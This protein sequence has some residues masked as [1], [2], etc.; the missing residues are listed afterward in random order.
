MN[1][2]LMSLVEADSSDDVTGWSIDCENTKWNPGLWF[3]NYE[4]HICEQGI[5]IN[6]RI[7]PLSK[8]ILLP[9][10]KTILILKKNNKINLIVYA[11][12]HYQSYQSFN[13]KMA[14]CK[15]K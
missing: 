8:K 15:I 3:L 11:K 10:L 13:N 1:S 4:Y 5:A 14:S 9:Y 12:E 6:D 2:D 7:L